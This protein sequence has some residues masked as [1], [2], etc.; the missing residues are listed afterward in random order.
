MALTDSLYAWYKLDEASGVANDAHSGAY[1]LSDSGGS[2]GVAGVINNGRGFVAT[3]TQ[4]VAAA[5][6][7]PF[8]L[9]SNSSF[10]WFFFAKRT[11]TVGGTNPWLAKM[12]TG[13]NYD[14]EFGIRYDEANEHVVFKM[15]GLGGTV[16]STCTGTVAMTVGTFY[17]VACTYNAATNKMRISV[18]DQATPDETDG[19]GA[20]ESSTGLLT[21]G[22]EVPSVIYGNVVLD[23]AAFFFNYVLTAADITYLHNGGA[24]RT[25]AEVIALGG[26]GN[27]NAVLHEPVIGG[28]NF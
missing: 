8:Q 27:L 4:Y 16:P 28:S 12:K 11:A 24:G 25:Y 18:N 9:G 23:E 21:L 15:T 5:T 26:A 20:T 14:S 1:H 13:G 7:A 17:S 19:A 22:A 3:S 2:T 6:E 10:S